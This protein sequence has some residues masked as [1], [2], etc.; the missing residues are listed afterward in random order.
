M[1]P[2]NTIVG[3]A[4]LDLLQRLTDT[5]HVAFTLTDDEGSVVASTAGRPAG[6]I[7]MYAALVARQDE[8]LEFGEE[9]LRAPEEVAHDS[10]A[11]EHTGLLQPAHGV[12]VPVKIG[13]R[14]AA[15]LFALGVPA[16]VR[17]M[18]VTAA[19]SAGLAL[20]FACGATRSMEQTLG[21][22]LALRALLRGTQ[23]EARRATM[24]VRVAGWDLL[25]PRV[26]LVIIPAYGR[27]QLPES[28]NAVV[29]ELLTALIPN[30]PSGQLGAAELV[31]LPPLPRDAAAPDIENVAGEIESNLRDQGLPV[32]IGLGETHIDLPILPGL[33]RSYRE[34]LFSAQ[35]CQKLGSHS[36]V[37]T[38]RGL[39]PL[40]FLAPGLRGRA[41][42]AH[43]LLDPL[44]DSP[45][46]M[47]T[48]RAFI[49]SDLSIEATARLTGQHRHT[50]RT[51]LQRA[52]ELSGLDPR[53]LGDAMQLKLALLLVTVQTV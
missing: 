51:Q 1:T 48:L 2:E 24:L 33:R 23:S 26:A 28:T 52:R 46:L 19:A 16:E 32:M 47:E 22:D 12:Y 3:P 17:L 42:F 53:V 4:A 43:Q 14:T 10:P 31:A 44:Q 41:R 9:Q 18:A 45:D 8:V 7:D 25:T 38:L 6:Q 20:E 49:D 29:R 36:G 13:G 21:P 27:D 37:H 34:A 30:T 39:G 15:V 40:A 35:W 5:L 11:A 50:V